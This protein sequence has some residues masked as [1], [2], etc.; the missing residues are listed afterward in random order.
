MSHKNALVMYAKKPSPGK[1]KTRLTKGL[2]P[3]THQEASDFYQFMLT[4]LIYLMSRASGYDFFICPQGDVEEFKTTFR[5][6]YATIRDEGNGDLGQSLYKSFHQLHEMGYQHV[7]IIGSDVPFLTPEKIHVAFS[8]PSHQS[9][10]ILGPDRQGGCYLIGGNQ[11]FP[12]FHDISWSRGEDFQIL[13]NRSRNLGLATTL[14]S[15]EMDIDTI[16]DFKA[17]GEVL[18]KSRTRFQESLPSL[19]DFFKM[20]HVKHSLYFNL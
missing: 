4:D 3:L 20:F 18:L 13:L 19:M 16:E 8:Y 12:I 2:N 6:S 1:V 17:L 5:S 15:Q 9:T 11:P 14:L 10:F 7:L